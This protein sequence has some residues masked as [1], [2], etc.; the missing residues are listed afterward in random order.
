ML[1]RIAKLEDIPAIT[2][3][4]NESIRWGKATA[5]RKEVSEENRREWFTQHST[6]LYAVFV[7]EI[8]GEVVGYL[9]VGPYRKGRQA[10]RH[11]AEV[12]YFVDFNHHR[13][14][15]AKALLETAF[16]HCKKNQVHNL[17]AFLMEHNEGSIQFLLKSG[18]ELW[19]RF[20]N[21]LLIDG[22]EYDHLIYG[23]K[24]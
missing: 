24:L 11:V 3:I 12:S 18:F 15:I 13:K 21:T 1:I 5:I 6:K 4:L 14:G 23:K 10:F 7:A 9:S 8:E 20:P 17:L 22:V 19:G 2:R 16:S